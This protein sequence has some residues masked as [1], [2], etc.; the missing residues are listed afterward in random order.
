MKQLLYGSLAILALA[1]AFHLGAESAKS[2]YVDHSSVGVVAV[3]PD[4]N[5]YVLDENG[6]VWLIDVPSGWRDD[7]S[8]PSLPVPVSQVKFWTPNMFITYDNHAWR[9]ADDEWVDMGAWPGGAVA[10]EK[11]SWGRIK[12]DFKE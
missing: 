9:T 8:A 11:R 2:G 4:G 3:S 6:V 7:I 5:P 10:T 1:L 12:A